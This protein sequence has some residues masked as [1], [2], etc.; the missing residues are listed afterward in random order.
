M[1]KIVI[2]DTS[3]LIILHK[4]G[5]LDLLHRVYHTVVTT[6]EVSRDEMMEVLFSVDNGTV[7]Q[8]KIKTGIQNKNFI[9]VVSGV[10]ENES[11]IVAPY[12]AISKKLKDSD[13]VQVVP[14]EELFRDPKKK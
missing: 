3:C 5:E 6:P 11:V 2:S 7:S 14:K 10:S 13:K 8:R 4:I 1:H 12:N 9:E